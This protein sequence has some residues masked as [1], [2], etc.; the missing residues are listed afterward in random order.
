MSAPMAPTRPRRGQTPQ[1]DA[2]PTSDALAER[3]IDAA[4][5]E[6]TAHGLRRVTVEDIAR[7]AGLHRVTVHKRFATKDE[8]TI[9]AM[10][11]WAQRYFTN[12]AQTVAGLSTADALVEGFVLSMQ[13]IRTDPL[14]ARLLD[15]DPEPALPYLTIKGGAALAVL[16]GFFATQMNPTEV[17]DSEGT[18]EVAARIGL[19]FLLTPDSHFRL[20]TTDEIR[21]FAR[22]YLVPILRAPAA[23]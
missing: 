11:T 18:A 8:L 16:R 17:D 3:I 4:I 20:D 15:D 6:V 5:A 2:S 21:A 10:M 23:T 13:T 12:I 1:R 19:S 7:R 9:A 14:V 22:R